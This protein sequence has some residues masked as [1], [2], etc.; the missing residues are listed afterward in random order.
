MFKHAA[1]AALTCTLAA[2]AAADEFTI[3]DLAPEHAMIIVG[4]DDMSQAKAAFDRTGMNKVWNDPSV[5][6]WFA[7][8]SSEFMD[9]IT[10]TLE[11]VGFE[12][13]D[14]TIPAGATGFS[15]WLTAP[16]EDSIEPNMHMFLFADY[17]NDADAMHQLVVELIEKGEEEDSFSLSQDDY[18]DVPIFTMKAPEQ[19]ADEDEWNTQSGPLEMA[20]AAHDGHLFVATDADL[21]HHAIDTVMGDDTDTIGADDAYRA[22]VSMTGASNIHATVLI[23]PLINMYAEDMSAM[24]DTLGFSDIQS[25]SM[26]AAL[27]TANGVMETTYALH[28]PEKNGLVA[29]L[30]HP[31]GSFSPPAFISDDVATF[32]TFKFDFAGIPALLQKIMQQM[33][34]GGGMI[35]GMLPMVQPILENLG[36]DIH[37]TQSFERPFSPDSQKQLFVIEVKDANILAQT[38]SST[39]AMMGLQSRDFMGN[40]I[41]SAGAQGMG[42]DISIGLGFGH[43]FVGPTPIVEN[44]M[45]LASNPGD[46]ALSA[47]DNFKRAAA[48]TG[49]GIGFSYSDLRQTMEWADWYMSNM[50]QIIEKQIAQAFAGIPDEE[51][52]EEWR[53]QLIE[54][55]KGEIPSWM[56]SAPQIGDLIVEILGD[57]ITEYRSTPEGFVGTTVML[58]PAGN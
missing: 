26:G 13:D 15:M 27:D 52:D 5:Q 1:L 29:L 17:K 36:P 39:G 48:T 35:A 45:R 53:D 8:M 28:V 33:P 40:Q 49:R 47:S 55:A 11:E 34:D 41:W 56:R 21:L 46:N 19:D 14:L 10:T 9:E 54:D 16:E 25:I 23:Q 37:M 2:H 38:I 3:A 58:R 18:R 50:E 7:E 24:M 6:K 30:D 44:A 57:S 51:M 31:A 43:L 20:Y 32:T 4:V 12:K 42:V 22:A